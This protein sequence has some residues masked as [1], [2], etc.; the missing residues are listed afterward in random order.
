[1]ILFL[2]YG[3]CAQ[4]SEKKRQSI[5]F[6]SNMY[7]AIF[8]SCDVKKKAF[9]FSKEFDHSR[10]AGEKTARYKELFLISTKVTPRPH[11]PGHKLTTSFL[12][13]N[14]PGSEARIRQYGIMTE[15]LSRTISAQQK[16]ELLQMSRSVALVWSPVENSTALVFRVSPVAIVCNPDEVPQPYEWIQDLANPSALNHL[17]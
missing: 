12:E 5:E 14:G 4:E 13:R 7:N 3:N 1:M 10:W 8:C 16:M 11:Q 9:T 17:V 6:S 15:S 2:F